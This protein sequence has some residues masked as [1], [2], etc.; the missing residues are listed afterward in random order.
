[1]QVVYGVLVAT[2]CYFL[3]GYAQYLIEKR[4]KPVP[5][6]PDRMKEIL[7]VMRS[8]DKQLASWLQQT[9]PLPEILVSARSINK[10]AKYLFRIVTAIESELKSHAKQSR[11]NSFA[12]S[13]TLTEHLD[14]IRRMHEAKPKEL[15]ALISVIS[16]M[17]KLIFGGTDHKQVLHYDERVADEEY[18][19]REL[20]AEHPE[21]ERQEATARVRDSST[22]KNFRLE[23]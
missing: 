4:R 3:L 10:E 16:R 20:M 18:R 17:E 6:P 21:M 23:G 19:V 1:M 2:V 7:D 12:L 8:I 5:S 9:D 11:A 14:Q 13:R 15:E 22:W